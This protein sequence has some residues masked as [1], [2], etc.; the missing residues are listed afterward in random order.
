M[1]FLEINCSKPLDCCCE[2]WCDLDVCQDGITASISDTE[3]V[4]STISGSTRLAQST[5]SGS[6]TLTQSTISGSTTL[7]QSTIGGSTEGTTTS[8][9][10]SL[11]M[12]EEISMIISKTDTTKIKPTSTGSMITTLSKNNHTIHQSGKATQIEI[13]LE[14][15]IRATINISGTSGDHGSNDNEELFCGSLYRHDHFESEFKELYHRDEI[16]SFRKDN[17]ILSSL[18]VANREL[19]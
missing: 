10:H 17:N 7:A 11:T 19:I 16:K 1:E 12:N 8:L 13:Q 9:I 15:T 14:A 3:L 5:I 4:T 6:A 2:G 18:Q